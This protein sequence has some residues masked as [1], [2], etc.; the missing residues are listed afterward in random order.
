MR[1]R[2]WQWFKSVGSTL[3][4][5]WVFTNGVAQATVVPSESMLPTIL[6]GDH[7]FLDKIAFPANYRKR[8]RN[9]CR[10]AQSSAAKS[11]RCGRLR[12]RK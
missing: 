11:S 1:K 8:F 5:V 4:F 9:I 7:F 2:L 6:V 10:F 3:A 12:I